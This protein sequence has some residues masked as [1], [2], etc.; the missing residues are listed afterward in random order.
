MSCCETLAISAGAHRR[1][2]GTDDLVTEPLRPE[3]FNVHLPAGPG[4]GVVLDED[5]L[6]R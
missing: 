4:I 6:R 1:W 3:D 2:K 5:K